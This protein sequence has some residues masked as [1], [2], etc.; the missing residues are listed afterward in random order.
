MTVFFLNQNRGG[1]LIGGVDT[2][3]VTDLRVRR[4]RIF[5]MA[6]GRDG[7]GGEVR[8]RRVP[9]DD[10]ASQSFFFGSDKRRRKRE[11]TSRLT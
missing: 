3:A 4:A 8:R 11:G 10:A 6:R 7:G 9:R 1:A 2:R 5:G